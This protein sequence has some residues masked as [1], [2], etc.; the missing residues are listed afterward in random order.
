MTQKLLFQ[1]KDT[2]Q[3]MLEL[4]ELYNISSYSELIK[5]NQIQ[6]VCFVDKDNIVF[7][8]NIKGFLGNPGGSVEEGERIEDTLRRELIE[9]AQLQLINF[10]TIGYEKVTYP[11]DDVADKYF[12]RVASR[13]KLIDKPINDPAG[14]AVGRVI[15]PVEKAAETLNW[16]EKGNVLVKLALESIDKLFT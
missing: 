10:V 4:C 14:K 15:V 8:K 2:W 5:I 7:Y 3:G 16:G 13:V 12:L 11:M 6:S 1:G 9:E